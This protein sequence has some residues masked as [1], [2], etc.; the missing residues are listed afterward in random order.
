ME[1]NSTFGTHVNDPAER[2]NHRM[3]RRVALF[4]YLD[5]ID[6]PIY[7]DHILRNRKGLTNKRKFRR[8]IL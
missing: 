6:T 2:N 5:A 1:N 8:T 7:T 4:I 3:N